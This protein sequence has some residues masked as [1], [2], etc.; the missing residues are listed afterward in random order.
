MRDDVA[1]GSQMGC[2]RWWDV[3]KQSCMVQCGFQSSEHPGATSHAQQQFPVGE[4]QSGQRF[5]HFQGVEQEL[6]RPQPFVR[7]LGHQRSM[8]LQSSSS[9]GI[10]SLRSEYTSE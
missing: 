6:P 3:A 4:G 10:A 2:H 8:L 5:R 7:N 1:G 9:A